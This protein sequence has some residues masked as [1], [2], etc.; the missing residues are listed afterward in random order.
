M[1]VSADKQSLLNEP[2]LEQCIT[3]GHDGPF[4]VRAAC[5][6]SFVVSRVG[7]S[8]WPA[9]PDGQLS[10]HQ[11]LATERMICQI[12]RVY[13]SGGAH[14]AGSGEA[15]VQRAAQAVAQQLGI[16]KEA[17]L[18]ACLVADV[19]LS[20]H[21]RRLQQDDDEDSWDE[22]ISSKHAVSLIACVS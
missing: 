17:V 4:F 8:S 13:P 19:Q 6:Q 18:P 10:A 21:G 11:V 20:L 12:K 15:A 7:S 22:G 2:V 5:R 1:G 9:E 3:A 14:F 16:E